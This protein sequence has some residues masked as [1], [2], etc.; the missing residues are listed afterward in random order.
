MWK[1]FD[2]INIEQ[3]L[4]VWKGLFDFL[5]TVEYRV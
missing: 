3:R 2:Y 4:Q 5:I 1:Q